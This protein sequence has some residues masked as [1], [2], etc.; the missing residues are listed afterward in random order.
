MSENQGEFRISVQRIG[1]GANFF[2]PVMNVDTEIKDSGMTCSACLSHGAVF[3]ECSY[4]D[5]WLNNEN[6]DLNSQWFLYSVCVFSRSCILFSV[7]ISGKLYK[8]NTS[9]LPA[10]P[11]PPPS[12]K[13]YMDVCVRCPL[14]FNHFFSLQS[15]AFHVTVTSLICLGRS[16]ILSED[17]LGSIASSPL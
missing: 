17:W 12:S 2:W 16:S 9:L 11:P 4:S 6:T 15:A 8:N 14:V 1:R 10:T 7:L 3:M 13:Q 5:A